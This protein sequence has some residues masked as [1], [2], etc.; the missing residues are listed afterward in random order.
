M[1]SFM[2]RILRQVVTV[3]GKEYSWGRN[4]ALG[5]QLIVILWSSVLYSIGQ[6][7]YGYCKEEEQVREKFEVNLVFTNLTYYVGQTQTH[8][9][10]RNSSSDESFPG[11]LRAEFNKW[12]SAHEEA[13]H[14]G[15]DVIDDNHHYRHNE[16][17]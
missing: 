3:C 4:T 9:D 7:K 8:E 14:V 1:V 17:D 13:K 11:L 16:P 15:H 2:W 5:S 10:G 6:T 12:S